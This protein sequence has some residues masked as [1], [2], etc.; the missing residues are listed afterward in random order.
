MNFPAIEKNR[1]QIVAPGLQINGW[2]RSPRSGRFRGSLAW[3]VVQPGIRPR[4]QVRMPRG[5]WQGF[6][7]GGNASIMSLQAGH[8]H[9]SD[10]HSY[11]GSEV[12]CWSAKNG[13][14]FL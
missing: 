6:S 1:L 8:R 9:R 13:S 5:W 4:Q 7:G 2:L 3:K 12:L 10:A 11:P 14:A